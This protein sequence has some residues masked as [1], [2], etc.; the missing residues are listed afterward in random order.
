MVT[1]RLV[2]GWVAIAAIAA[3]CGGGA[4]DGN[5]N[6]IAAVA[7]RTAAVTASDFPVRISLSGTLKGDRQT[8]LVCRIQSTVLST[9]VRVGDRVE[10]GQKLIR[11]DPGGVQSQY[12]QLEALYRDAEKQLEKMRSLYASGAVS[13]RDLDRT[14]TEFEVARANFGAARQ[15]VEIESPIAGVVTDLYVRTGDEVS[16]GVR[17]LEVADVS[18]LR[19]SLEVPSSQIGLLAIGQ[20]VEVRSPYDT[21]R[22]MNGSVYSIADAA[23]RNTRSFEVECT[24]PQPRRGFAPGT[25]VTADITVEVLKNA[26]SLPDEAIIYRAGEAMTYVVVADSA[27]LVPVEVLAHHGGRAAIEAELRPQDRVVVTGQ[28]NLSPGAPVREAES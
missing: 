12:R 3:G 5:H 28:K 23:D 9:D 6:D 7:V 16:P 10:R 24:F 21:S 25:F 26:L 4:A 14:E 13:E 20:P 8:V 19:L 2:I 27:R 17:L 22:V 11:L 1:T 15:Q 18:T